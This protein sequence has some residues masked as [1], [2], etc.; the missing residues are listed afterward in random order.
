[1]RAP[2]AG[3][4]HGTAGRFPTLDGAYSLETEPPPDRHAARRA[5]VGLPDFPYAQTVPTPLVAVVNDLWERKPAVL[6]LGDLAEYA[7]GM[8]PAYA[9]KLLRQSGWLRPL[10]SRGVWGVPMSFSRVPGF[11]ELLGRL[12]VVP[13][14]PACIAGL[15]VAFRSS[16][17]H[18]QIAP[19]IGFPPDVKLPRCL[20]HFIVHR[21]HPRAPLV[22]IAGL[23][24]WSMDTLIV[25]MA[26][27]P[28]R[29]PWIY[30]G[31][32]LD[33]GCEELTMTGVLTELDGRSRAVWHKAAYL[34]H[35]G[36]RHDIADA[37]LDAAP[38]GTGPYR[39][40]RRREW[41]TRPPRWSPRFEV[42][43]HILPHKWFP[44][45]EYLRT[46]VVIGE[47]L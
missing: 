41:H 26:A 1:M 18:V 35:W 43:D 17:L 6:T 9:A 7:V 24:A 8:E 45:R 11:E 19:T 21:W 32:W 47:P 28:S 10:R 37:V 22:T 27:K 42:V 36:D 13:E 16:W 14:T 5:A 44:K 3:T 4:S 38:T 23:P 34:A 20:D 30:I 40:G 39:L 29:F 25:F 2:E 12:A 46:G 15:S 31:D 33:F